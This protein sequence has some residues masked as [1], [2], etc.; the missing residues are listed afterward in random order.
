MSAIEYEV[1]S[2][3]QLQRV[4]Q[5]YYFHPSPRPPFSSETQKGFYPAVKAQCVVALRR[6]YRLFSER[7]NG[8]ALLKYS[9]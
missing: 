6:D 3:M 8:Y 4:C 2:L 9:T 1:R 5:T 7:N